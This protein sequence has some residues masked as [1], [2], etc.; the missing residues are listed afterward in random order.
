MKTIISF[1]IQK[2]SILKSLKFRIWVIVMLVGLISSSI[3]SQNILSNYRSRAVSQ[4]TTTAVSQFRILANHLASA[5]YF[6]DK[7]QE[8]IE[9]ELSLFSSFFSGRIMIIDSNFNVVSDSYQMSVGKAMIASEIINCFADGNAVQ[10][11]DDVN[12]YIELVIPIFNPESETVEG[13]IFASSSTQSVYNTVDVLSRKAG[14]LMVAMILFIFIFA[15]VMSSILV[16]PFERITKVINSVDNGLAV[17]EEKILDYLETEEI[18]NAFNTVLNRM[19]ILDESREEFVSNVSHEL[20]TPLASMK[21]LADSIRNADDVPIETYKEFMD[22]IGDEVDRENTIITDLLSLVKMDKTSGKPNIKPTDVNTMIAGI[23]KRLKP[24]GDKN[25]IE[26]IFN[27]ERTVN[28]EIDETKMTLAITNLVENAIKYNKPGG[29][30][31]VDLDADHQFFSCKVSDS[32]IGIPKDSLDRIY[33]RFYRVDKSHS[34]EIGGTGLGLAI[35]RSA[36]LLHRGAI[37]ATSIEGEG[38]TFVVRIPL[39]YVI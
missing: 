26:L 37:K 24:I 23:I 3:M 35:T 4:Q 22:D 39:K 34:R 31:R 2:S 19:R 21:V 25:D 10:N 5:D 38:T 32:G 33:E 13:V 8:S 1:L 28:A 7:E 12:K 30:V 15:V 14:I 20:K 9:N 36:I 17:P 18:M 27:E 6:N 11:Y 29:W 16:R